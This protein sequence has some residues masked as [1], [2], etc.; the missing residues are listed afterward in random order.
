MSATPLRS[1]SEDGWEHAFLEL[2]EENERLRRRL[3]ELER[4]AGQALM[5]AT[6]LAQVVTLLGRPEGVS[7]E[8]LA[9]AATDIASLFSADVCALLVGPD[10]DLALGCQWGV[11]AHALPERPVALPR[12]LLA[13]LPDDRVLVS[14]GELPLP[15][16]LAGCGLA[17]LA[18]TRL[19][20]TKGVGIMVVG[21]RADEPFSREDEA[22]LRAIA[23]RLATALENERLRAARE[24][25]LTR[26]RRLHAL[27]CALSAA[28]D[29]EAVARS[30]ARAAVDDLQAS[31]CAVYI[32]RNG[33]LELVDAR[34][35]EAA[36]MPQRLAAHDPAGALGRDVCVLE[37]RDDER[38]FGVVAVKPAPQA[39]SELDLVVRSAT[40]VGALALRRALLWERTKEQAKLD[41][42]TGLPAHRAFHERFEELLVSAAGPVSLALIDIDNFKQV[43]DRFG[44]PVGDDALRALADVLRAGTRAHDE[45]FRIGGE[46]FA[47]L[48]PATDATD[49]LRAATRLCEVVRA[50]PAPVPLTI[51]VGV[52]QAGLH[53]STR[54]ELVAAADAALY[55]AKR[56]GKDRAVLATRGDDTASGDR[57]TQSLARHRLAVIEGGAARARERAEGASGPAGNQPVRPEPQPTGSVSLT[58]V[59]ATD[60]VASTAG[61]PGLEVGGDPLAALLAALRRR[62]PTTALHDRLALRLVR[63]IGEHA[64]V[65]RHVVELAE[66]AATVHA[67]GKL[68]WP[69]RILRGQRPLSG[70]EYE[71][72]R[73]HTLAGEALLRSIGRLD[74]A[75]VVRQHHERFDGSGYPDGLA[76][77]EIPT[78]ARLLHLADALA[79]MSLDRPYRR[80]L[81]PAQVR[82]EL[83][84]GRGRQF[85]PELAA[86]ALSLPG[87][88]FGRSARC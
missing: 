70:A 7:G 27:T 55:R 21:R 38:L 57:S 11:P 8:S 45:P 66:A 64:G 83:Q 48:M 2:R 22:E 20:G 46:E 79:A 84:R 12:A 68:T 62:D 78:A 14:T 44:H 85:D 73:Y 28:I 4:Q 16:W 87:A 59:P 40:D 25:Q 13:K 30:L 51:S 9:L 65:E 35:I 72:V 81:D 76:A 26:L 6:R 5:R 29:P 10:D 88:P 33:G 18:W 49:A 42:L 17:H 53:G 34:G 15:E 86:A 50:A 24:R 74:V 1:S 54:D 61:R 75:R 60:R 56:A 80:A 32:A 67:L 71:V 37:L 41:S 82:D 77:D 19:V 58:P 52:A 63:E 23:Y 36:R 3:R 43:N 69:E 39:G 47:V 31:A